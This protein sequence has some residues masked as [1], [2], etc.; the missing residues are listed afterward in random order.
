LDRPVT[1]YGVETLR[2][3]PAALGRPLD[4]VDSVYREALWLARDDWR[5]CPSGAV[6]AIRGALMAV[7]WLDGT[8]DVGFDPSI[9]CPPHSRADV[10]RQI[11]AAYRVARWIGV[12]D[13]SASTT[14]FAFWDMLTFALGRS[15]RSPVEKALPRY[16][17][18]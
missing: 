18:A 13:E 10:E 7:D 8:T 2:I 15:D 6:D 4:D 1:L 11:V 17:A 14:V 9:P 3:D 5:R 12:G 16:Q